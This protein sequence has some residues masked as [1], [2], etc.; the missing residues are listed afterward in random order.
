[1]LLIKSFVYIGKHISIARNITAMLLSRDMTWSDLVTFC[2]ELIL[3]YS[4]T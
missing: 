3:R 1:M 4:L 2:Y